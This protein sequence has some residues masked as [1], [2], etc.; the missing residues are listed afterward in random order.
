MKEDE[1]CE[2]EG[3]KMKTKK[4]HFEKSFHF[5][6]EVVLIKHM[7]LTKSSVV[8]VYNFSFTSNLLPVCR[9]EY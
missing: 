7:V 5:N 6:K 1:K 9:G 4:C 2:F 3:V 8:L